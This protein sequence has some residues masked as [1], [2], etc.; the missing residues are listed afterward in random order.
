MSILLLFIQGVVLDIYYESDFW[1][2]FINHL[3]NI[4]A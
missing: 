3:Y 2:N 4:I 1:W